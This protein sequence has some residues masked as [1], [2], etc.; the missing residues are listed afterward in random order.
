MLCGAVK[1]P[2]EALESDRYPPMLLCETGPFLSNHISIL[3]SLLQ[4]YFLREISPTLR[5]QSSGFRWPSALLN[6][7][8]TVEGASPGGFWK[9][10]SPLP[11]LRPL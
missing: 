9:L 5:V 6:R 2:A 8:E 11:P 3:L 1:Q 7:W 10:W 4:S